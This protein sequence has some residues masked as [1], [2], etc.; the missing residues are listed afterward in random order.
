MKLRSVRHALATLATLTFA[1][2]ASTQQAARRPGEA[3]EALSSAFEQIS[4]RVAPAVVQVFTSGVGMSDDR[5]TSL[6]TR[7]EGTASGVVIDPD[8]Y[9]VTNAHVVSGARRIQVQLAERSEPASRPFVVR[10]QG[11]KLEA[12]VVG[13]DSVTD[14]ALLKIAG[15]GLETLS[16]GN[17]DRL[18]QGQ[19]VLAFGSPLGLRNTMTM[20]VVSAVARQLSP[21]DAA[22]YVQTDAPV[23]PGN[24]GGPLVDA[25]GQ[26][27]GIN[28]LILSHSGGSEGVGLAIPSNVVRV[29]TDQLRARG[30]VRRGMIGVQLQAIDAVFAKALGLPQPWG[31]IVAD[32]SDDGPAGPAGVQ[33]GDVILSLDGRPVESVRQFSANVFRHAI[34]ATV[35]LEL[36]RGA[37]RLTLKV[38]VIE[39]PDDPD[40]YLSL[41]DPKKNLVPQLDILG[42][43]LPDEP[44]SGQRRRRLDGGVLVAAASEDAS[45][46]SR[47]LPGDVIHA[48]NRTFVLS[49]ADLR[50]A[51][52]DMKDGDP[53]VVQVERQGELMFIAFE[54]D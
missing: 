45:S 22:V 33:V 3:L 40:R 14:L 23:N 46:P 34:D 15:K 8:G 4:E 38:Q 5:Q 28:T 35:S 52:A 30:R 25:A 12:E 39:R 24:S 7:Q 37:D 10:P 43:D 20:G 48:V 41:V 13:V 31:V 44:G 17:S 26:V 19:V 49:L 21:D 47:F 42:I 9:I 29:I 53:V 2:T 11:V 51:I 32:V 36:L 27:V 18:K 54:I 50:A 16:L 1:A 6:L